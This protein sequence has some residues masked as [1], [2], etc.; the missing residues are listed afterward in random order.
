[1]VLFPMV[2]I[3]ITALHML[4]RHSSIELHPQLNDS[5]FTIIFSVI[6]LEERI[7]KIGTGTESTLN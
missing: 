4:A 3:R 6:L 2:R 7:W 5:S 1:M